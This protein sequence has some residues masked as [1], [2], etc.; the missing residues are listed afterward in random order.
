[1]MTLAHFG[2]LAPGFMHTNV[3]Q[4][5]TTCSNAVWPDHKGDN[6]VSCGERQFSQMFESGVVAECDSKVDRSTG[7]N[8]TC[9]AGF[10]TRGLTCGEV[11]FNSCVRASVLIAHRNPVNGHLVVR[12]RTRA[13]TRALL[14]P[15]LPLFGV[16]VL[17][18]PPA[19]FLPRLYAESPR[20]CCHRGVNWRRSSAPTPTFTAKMPGL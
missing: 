15:S 14:G 4:S 2:P 7:V 20:V 10:V 5:H 1:M 6:R 18:R 13:P 8:S 12:V 19:R 16:T 17:P 3:T 11:R 9:E